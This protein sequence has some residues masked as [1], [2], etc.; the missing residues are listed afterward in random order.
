MNSQCIHLHKTLATIL[1]RDNKM[2]IIPSRYIHLQNIYTKSSSRCVQFAF[3]RDN[4]ST[5]IIQV[6]DFRI[7]YQWPYTQVAPRVIHVHGLHP[8]S[9]EDRDQR[10]THCNIS[11]ALL[12]S[13]TRHP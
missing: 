10:V 2:P 3:T 9:E 13:V 1:P 11:N 4:L 8:Y 5:Y 7:N 6:I 12:G